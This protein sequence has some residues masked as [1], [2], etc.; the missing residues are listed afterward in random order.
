LWLVFLEMAGGL[1]TGAMVASLIHLP[2]DGPFFEP[3]QIQGVTSVA[4]RPTGCGYWPS[5]AHLVIRF[6]HAAW[7][8]RRISFWVHGGR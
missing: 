3:V 7:R 2:G 1:G 5:R 6:G 4:P 8:V